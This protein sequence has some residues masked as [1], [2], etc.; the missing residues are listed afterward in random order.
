MRR[1]FPHPR[2]MLV[3]AVL[4][5]LLVNTLNLGHVLLGLFLGGPSFICAATSCCMCRV[6][7]SRWGW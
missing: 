2:M 1:L 5:L 3:L 6:C 7:A 4:W